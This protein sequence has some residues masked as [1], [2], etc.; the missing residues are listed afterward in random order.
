LAST[1]AVFTAKGI[2]KLSLFL[3]GNRTYVCVAPAELVVLE[4]VGG[5]VVL[6]FVVVPGFEV[7]LCAVDV[8]LTE[9]VPDDAG[10]PHPTRLVAI[11]T[12]SN[13]T[14]LMSPL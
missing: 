1:L 12:S 8:D 10:P 13:Q 4:V 2:S 14:V 11:A 6:G 3:H 9:V 5:T 7:V